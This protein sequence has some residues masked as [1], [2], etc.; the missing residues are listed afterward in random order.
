MIVGQVFKLLEKKYKMIAI[1][2]VGIM[3]GYSS[4]KN[5]FKMIVEMIVHF[6]I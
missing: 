1:M 2:I 5:K 4:V 3:I 6:K